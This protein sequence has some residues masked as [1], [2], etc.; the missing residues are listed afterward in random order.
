MLLTN[1]LYFVELGD[2][3]KS[4]NESIEKIHKLREDLR[5]QKELIRESLAENN[6]LVQEIS[7]LHAGVGAAEQRGKDLRNEF[8]LLE[9]ADIAIQ[10]EKKHKLTEIQKIKD[11]IF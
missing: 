3:V 8:Q 1:M 2:G 10:N 9:R 7:G 6:Q 4:Y 11:T 5:K